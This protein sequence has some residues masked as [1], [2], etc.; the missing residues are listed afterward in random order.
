MRVLVI[1]SS[2]DTRVRIEQSLRHAMAD[3]TVFLW[4]PVLQGVPQP[5]LD[6]ARYDCLLLTDEP[7]GGSD[8]IEWLRE[9]HRIPHFPPTIFLSDSGSEERAVR[10]VRAGAFDYLRKAEV[11][12][13]KLAMTIKEARLEVSR[14]ARPDMADTQPI[15]L[16]SIGQPADPTVRVPGYRILRKIG[17]GGMSTVF[18]AEHESQ[19]QQ[20]VL[21]VL[22]QRMRNDEH[23]RK[24]LQREYRIIQ[25]IRNE[26]VA[27]VFDQG[28]DDEQAYIAMEYFSGGDLH[29]RIRA[30]MTSMAALKVLI[31]IAVA[32]DAVH[33]AGVVHRDLKPQNIM[34]RA[35]NRLAILDF[36]L[37]REMDAT[38]TLTQK[39]MVMAT[40][41][42][43]SPEQCIGQPHE[44]RGDLYS[45]GVILYEMLTGSHVYMGENA[46]Q[47]AYQHVHAPIPRLQGRLSGYQPLLN[48]L[49]AKSP[50]DR[51]QSARELYNFI[52]H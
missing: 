19:P 35:N 37:A 51:F 13:V 33:T 39:G 29:Q 27:V 36:G 42:Y 38:S 34:F 46:S 49:L 26:H 43:M 3:V 48:R 4:D 2:A 31:Q 28:F 32:L 24:R 15:R 21:K 23:F 16:D 25:R 14:A 1:E 9:F 20:I 40:P 11:T 12:P 7:L 8:A 45:T 5:Q 30:G 22:D 41:L 6:W 47:L 17:E 10:A 52:V 50:N 18:L 44:P